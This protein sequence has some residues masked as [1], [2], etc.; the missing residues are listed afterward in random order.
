MPILRDINNSDPNDIKQ[1]LP[2]LS[3]CGKSQIVA[4]CAHYL[5][6]DLVKCPPDD[7]TGT[8]NK[9]IESYKSANEGVSKLLFVSIKNSA[10]AVS[11]FELLDKIFYYYDV[12]N[13]FTSKEKMHQLFENDSERHEA[14]LDPKRLDEA[15]N[16]MYFRV[17]DNL[18]VVIGKQQKKN[19]L[20]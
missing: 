1:E 19:I 11:I 17:K 3:G 4:F 16:D 15:R 10:K 7:M 2:I 18:H 14:L 8:R 6:M 20:N 12:P 13:G 9:I 5:N